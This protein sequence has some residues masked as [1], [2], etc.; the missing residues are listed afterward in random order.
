MKILHLA[1]RYC[2][3][4]PVRQKAFIHGQWVSSKDGKT[5]PVLNPSTGRRIAEVSDCGVADAE[6]AI[7]SA[8]D[9]FQTWGGTTTKERSGV[10]RKLFELQ[11]KYSK[12]L[13]RIMTEEMGKSL[14]EA[15]GEINYG[16]SFLEWFSEEARRIYGEVIPSPVKNKLPVI[17]R[18]PVGVAGIITPWNFPNAMITRK[19]GAA[20]AAGCT[21]VIKPAEDT[22]LSALAFAQLAEEAKVPPGVIN[23]I[24][25]SRENT[26]ALG[27]HLCESPQIGTISFTG[28]TA[29]GKLLLKQSASTVKRVS[30]ELGGNAPTIVFDSANL[31]KAVPGV[32]ASKFRNSGQTC[33]CTNR[34]LVQSKIHGEFVDKLAQKI[35]Q[36]L[37]VGD[38]FDPKTN[39]GPLINN[40]AVQK[41]ERHVMDALDKGANVLLGGKRNPQGENFYEPTLITGVTRNMLVCQEETFGPVAA[42]VKFDTEDEAVTIA[43]STRAGLAGY[44]FS[45]DI[46]QVWRVAKRLEL[47]MVGVNEGLMSM[48]EAPFGGVKESGIGREGSRHGIDEYVYIKYVCFGSLE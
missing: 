22:P 25:A 21:C 10:L 11:M 42:V 5:F 48:A 17:L 4:F 31:E 13:A 35:K 7:Q 39:V 14:K 3:S 47:G 33:V 30:L 36:D 41:V 18:Q 37:F 38:G 26:P 1:I 8:H 28:S 6:E 9:A 29:V 12:D 44:L 32:M 16:A 34:I 20:L 24:T 45:E 2:S 23:I 15:E 27:K 46:S 43:N 19:V 40:N